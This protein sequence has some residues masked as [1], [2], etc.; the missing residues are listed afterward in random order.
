MHKLIISKDLNDRYIKTA[1]NH[2]RLNIV[3]QILLDKNLREFFYST[4]NNIDLVLLNNK[5]HVKNCDQSIEFEFYQ[6]HIEPNEINNITSK[7][8]SDNIIIHTREL[9]RPI[10]EKNVEELEHHYE[11]DISKQNLLD[12]IIKFEELTY[13]AKDPI[14]LTVEQDTFSLN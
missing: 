9:K 10:V 5:F 6:Q 4:L 7:Q 11:T 1:S 14:I 3:A 12:L 13:N 2:E 8:Y